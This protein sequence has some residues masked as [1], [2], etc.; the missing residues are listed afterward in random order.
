MEKRKIAGE[1]L[2]ERAGHQEVAGVGNQY[3]NSHLQITALRSNYGKTRILSGGGVDKKACKRRL[4]RRHAGILG[5]NAEC[6]GDGK[7]TQRDRNPMADSFFIADNI[8]F[9]HSCFN[10]CRKSVSA[11]A[12]RAVNAFGISFG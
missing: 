8:F 2:A 9:F 5:C 7:I 6:E 3:H 12:G 11:F 10:L 4:K 1:L